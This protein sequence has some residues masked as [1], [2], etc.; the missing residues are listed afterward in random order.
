M[1]SDEIRET[2]LSF[3]E[4]RG[5]LRVPS[6]SLVPAARRHLDPA[7]RRR[8]A[9]VQALLPGPR[10]AA[11]AAPD[12]LPALLS[13]P[14]H[15]GGRQDHAPPDLLRD[16]RQLQLRRLLQGRV[17]AL[18]LGALAARAS[19]STRSGSGSPSS[20]ATRSSASAP[21]RRRSRSGARSASPR[22]GSCGC[23]ARRTSGRPGPTGPVRAVLGAVHR[24]RPRVRPRRARPGDDTDRYLEYWNHVFMTYELHEDGSLTE[25][26]QRNIDT[27]LGLERMAVIQQGVD[28]VFDTDA[29][30]AADR[31]RRGALGP[32]LRLRRRRRRGRC[33]SSPTTRAA[34]ST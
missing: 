13:H 32:T 25:L 29:L 10:G 12:L 11:G 6:A 2:F 14:R 7:H 16:A 31:A 21:T 28:S 30:R 33:G 17:D 23:R 8:H 4:Q 20:P 15:R 19:A 9:A 5:H 18:R 26:P 27:G 24:P 22:S 1:T 3:F 34:R